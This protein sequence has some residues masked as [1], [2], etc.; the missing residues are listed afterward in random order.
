M[1][2]SGRDLIRSAGLL[3]SAA[4]IGS[5]TSARAQTMPPAIASTVNPP[6]L[7]DLTDFEC[8]AK[9]VM[10]PMTWE[11]VSGA[12]ADELTL[13]WNHEAYEKIRLMPRAL[14]DVSQLDT[15][16]TLLDRELAFPILLA[17]TAYQKI[18]HPD[19][20]LATVKGAGDAN[21]TMVLSTFSTVTL[22]EV[23]AAA[24]TPLWFQLYVQPDREFT[25]DLVHR[26]EVAGYQALVVT[27]DT[28]VLGP[29][30][31]ELR[32]KFSPPERANLRGLKGA[33]GAQ[34][35][36]EQSI[37]SLVLDPKLTWKDIDWL[38]SITKL[39]VL[40]KG[41]QNPADAERAVQAGV[42][43]IIVSNHG[44]RQLDTGPAT[45][46]SLPRVVEKVGGKMPV[47]VDGGIRRGTDILKAL[48]YGASAVLIGRP[49]VYGLAVDGA[50]G[51][52]RTVNILRRELE[53]AMAMCGRTSIASIDS[54][55]LWR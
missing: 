21:A 13:R 31:R 27:V 9:T 29:R 34:R 45:I 10:P 5:T 19:G 16:I 14:V 55:V 35:P 48:G 3:A 47:L 36:T 33:T 30:Y 6:D 51:V 50:R 38:R 17:P 53:S 20:E 41:V 12:A 52:T 22:E 25:R 39:P 49:Y 2:I 28:P 11:Y 24:K 43:G 42:A 46:E 37:F 18:S 8:A 54:S 23:A 1:E 40:L 44:A 4:V 15:R 26:A 32:A 7:L